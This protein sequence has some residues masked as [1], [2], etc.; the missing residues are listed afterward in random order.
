MKHK[1]ICSS[2]LTG[3]LA[4]LMLSSC[5]Q[6][7]LEPEKGFVLYYPSISEISPGSTL[8]I[9]PNWYGGSPDSFAI[10]SVTCNGKPAEVD[11]FTIDPD[12]GEFRIV[13]SDATAVG[14]YLVSVSC[15]V[16]GNRHSFADII[17]IQMMKPVPESIQVNPSSLN[18]SLSDIY[19][20]SS[21]NKLPTARISA[22]GDNHLKI[23]KYLFANIYRDGTIC[24]ECS[25][26]FS[27]S[28]DGVF[29]IT[30]GNTDFEPGVYNFD[31]KL[32]TYASGKDA[33][34]GI[35]ADALELNVTSGPLSLVYSPASL[36]VEKGTEGKSPRPVCKGSSGFTFS[37]KAVSPSLPGLDIE[38]DSGVLLFPENA[39]VNP[40]DSFAVDVTV[41]NDYGTADFEDAFSFQVIEFL[42]PITAFSY[43]D[44]IGCI[45]GVSF[46]NP[47]LEMDGD[48]VSY[49]FSDLPAEL[50]ALEIDH[51]TG[52]VTCG[53]GVEIA[54]GDYVV[55]LKAEN[56]KGT[57]EASFRLNVTANPNHF[58]YVRWG[59]NLSSDGSALQ[60]LEKYGNQFRLFHSDAKLA[61][62][63]VE[64]DIPEGRPVKFESLKPLKEDD[65]AVTGS[66]ISVNASTGRLDIYPKTSGYTTTYT[67][68]KVTVGEGEAAVVKKFPVFVDLCGYVDNHQILYTPFAI[69]VNPKTGGCSEAPVITKKDGD[70]NIADVSSQ[71]SLDYRTNSFYFNINGPESH[72]WNDK[73]QND[74]EKKS[75]LANVWQKYFT[76]TGENYNA[77]S[78]G[79]M[80]W[81][82]NFDKGYLDFTGAYVD[83]SDGLRIK[84]NPDRFR[85][86]DGNYANGVYWG[87]MNFSPSG[88]N[89]LTSS[90]AKQVNRVFLWFDPEYQN[91]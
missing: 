31:F 89:P 82:Y 12:T 41:S 58:T 34:D 6:T 35:F 13:A 21:G 44:I 40:G 84:I 77:Y 51:H 76:A 63:I 81:W 85:D 66:N 49:S 32:T 9:K 16:D 48:E 74:T 83:G 91:E 60:P 1:N 53:S 10:E 70:G 27:L 8:G 22:D 30:P 86:A 4:L 7:A 90:D 36:R 65:S 87:T 79:P 39:D 38:K 46:S 2:L 42:H 62:E 26:W 67:L 78:A 71:V 18:V 23:E 43:A 75:F 59:N 72:T 5:R 73:V 47:V 57:M 20:E 56:A 68:I 50:S 17:K 80:S 19:S 64:S 14:T 33:E 37:I 54:P 88:A 69:R 25:G 3:L 55:K 45:S 15:S 52:E 61:Q 11:C 29:S 28:D 24:N